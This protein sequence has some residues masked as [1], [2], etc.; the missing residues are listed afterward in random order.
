[1][2]SNVLVT[3]QD[4]SYAL[5]PRLTLNCCPDTMK[6][7]TDSDDLF[8]IF[9]LFLMSS[10]FLNFIVSGELLRVNIGARAYELSCPVTSTVR[11]HT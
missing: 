5:V 2:T 11:F 3:G 10:K 9:K 1:M 7:N 8:G 4:S 6:F